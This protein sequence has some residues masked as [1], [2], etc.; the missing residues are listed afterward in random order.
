MYEDF[1]LEAF[2]GEFFPGS[3]G[4]IAFFICNSKAGNITLFVGMQFR[5]GLLAII[6]HQT[7][8]GVKS[9]SEGGSIDL[10]FPLNG[11]A[12]SASHVESGTASSNIRV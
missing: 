8:S 11:L 1:L 4:V 12:F 6:A 3:G 7:A 10:E 2:V 5:R 9:T